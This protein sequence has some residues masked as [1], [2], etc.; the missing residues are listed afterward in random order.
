MS[1]INGQFKYA[2]RIIFHKI[3]YCIS[4]IERCST[5]RRF[6]II[7]RIQKMFQSVLLVVQRHLHFREDLPYLGI[8]LLDVEDGLD[9]VGFVI[10]GY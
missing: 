6:V 10:L 9:H 4:I 8:L 1:I 7:V 3:D 5:P 2:L